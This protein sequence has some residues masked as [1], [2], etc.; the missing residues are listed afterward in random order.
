MKV[1]AMYLPQFHRVKENDEWW[2]EGF[3]DW[4]A[5]R[6]AKKLF[7]GHY[8]PHTP[9]NEN[10]YNLLEKETMQW[11]ANLMQE[12]GIDG[13][14]MYH[15]WFKDGRQILEKPAENLLKWKDINMPYCFCWA[16]E[17]WA[18]SWSKLQ[19]AN[20]WSNILEENMDQS[21]KAVLL[22]QHYGNEE[23]WKKHFAYLKPFFEDE[24]YIKIDGKPVFLIYKSS[25][26][27]CLN[28]MIEVWQEC[29]KDAGWEGVYIVGGCRKGAVTNALDA[30]YIHEPRNAIQ[31]FRQNNNTV[32]T[33][34]YSKL[35]DCILENEQVESVRT[36]YWGC[37]GYDSTP[38]RGK[39]GLVLT[40]NT[41]ELFYQYMK[42][43]L[44]KSRMEGNEITFVN[45]W[46]EWG[47]G[48]HL[49]PDEKY[50][51]GYLEALKRA[52][53]D[54]M[55]YVFEK[56]RTELSVKDKVKLQQADKHELYMNTLDVWLQLLEAGVKISDY[57]KD[58]GFKRIGVYGYGIMYRHF[59]RQM[60]GAETKV[61]FLVD[62]RK[63]KLNINLPIF[64]P[65]DILP[66]NDAIIVTSFYYVEEVKA[67]LAKKQKIYSLREIIYE[68]WEEIRN[69]E[70]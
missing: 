15:Y 42:K 10:Y 26:I 19:E 54:S 61:V 53:S 67:K 28:E 23:A 36:F 52:K 29:A 60:E 21:S 13:V 17:T 3:T 14:C 47:E 51:Y 66:E 64:L 43:L 16:N 5:A 46:N 55:D 30:E 34:D 39:N 25:D 68:I 11:Q 56:N 20:V 63:E 41:P 9:L 32:T 38:R 59:M 69:L 4:V 22:E 27:F 8:Q 57:F 40:N 65:E 18:R 2:G 33:I 49:E 45:A 70:N 6:D 48:M 44:A 35:W 7:E 50:Q 37:V 58:K 1:I 12:Y 31:N 62:Q 24:R